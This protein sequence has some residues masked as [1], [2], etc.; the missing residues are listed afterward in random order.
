M[1]SARPRNEGSSFHARHSDGIH[2]STG[3]RRRRHCSRTRSSGD[4]RCIVAGENTAGSLPPVHPLVEVFR[5]AIGDFTVTESH[6]QVLRG[7]VEQPLPLCVGTLLEH[8]AFVVFGMR[9]RPWRIP[10]LKSE[11]FASV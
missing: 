2:S 9:S 3:R 8:R 10:V 7:G 1:A 4:S 11:T 5:D 6:D